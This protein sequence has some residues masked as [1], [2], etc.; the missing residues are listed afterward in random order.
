MKTPKQH[1]QRFR[2][3][4]NQT[5]KTRLIIKAYIKKQIPEIEKNSHLN[6]R[7][8]EK[9][10]HDLIQCLPTKNKKQ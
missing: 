5:K 1:R 9:L 7:V 6:P 2:L 3:L 10:I 4:K 8:K